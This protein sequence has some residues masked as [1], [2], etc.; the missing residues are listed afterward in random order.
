LALVFIAARVISPLYKYVPKI[1]G[2]HFCY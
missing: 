1:A 2:Q